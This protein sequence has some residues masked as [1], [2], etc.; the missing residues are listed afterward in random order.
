MTVFELDIQ[1]DTLLMLKISNHDK[2]LRKI[3]H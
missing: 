2:S 1:Y 3:S